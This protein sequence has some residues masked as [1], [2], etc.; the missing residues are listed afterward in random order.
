MYLGGSADDMIFTGCHFDNN[1]P[2]GTNRLVAFGGRGNHTFDNC[3]FKNNTAQGI[4]DTDGT[5]KNC[6]LTGNTCAEM[7]TIS[8]DKITL[9][10]TVV[11]ENKSTHEYGVAGVDAKELIIENSAVYK[12]TNSN[13]GRTD[14]G[15]DCSDIDVTKMKDPTDASMDFAGYTVDEK[16]TVRIKVPTFEAE[17]NGKKYEKLT[18]AVE[19]AKPGDT[20]K[21]I[22]TNEAGDKKALM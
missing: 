3:T 13:N 19:E 20:I 6:V 9:I 21:I 2:E 1:T 22:N 14:L 17:I 15:E 12:N 7:A 5:Y 18:E 11:K 16:G 8:G 4:A 10:N